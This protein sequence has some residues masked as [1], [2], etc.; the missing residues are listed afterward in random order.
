MTEE[1]LTEKELTE[2]ELME[3]QNDEVITAH[4]N[5]MN[6]KALSEGI[7]L[8][9]YNGFNLTTLASSN[10]LSNGSTYH[11]NVTFYG[12]VS[13][14]RLTLSRNY[15][16]VNVNAHL[17]DSLPLN[18]DDVHIMGKKTFTAAVTDFQ[19]INVLQIRGC[20]CLQLSTKPV[21]ICNSPKKRQKLR[22]QGTLVRRK[23]K[24]LTKTFGDIT[25][26]IFRC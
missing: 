14:G 13:V 20:P 17:A 10:L 7:L 9:H 8:G 12:D 19:E 5:F 16:G 26:K 3:E 24:E 2:E 6:I 25:K 1:E 22:Y 4:Y 18:A 15:N 23:G 21:L 11:G